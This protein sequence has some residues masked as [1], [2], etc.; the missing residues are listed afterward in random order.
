MSVST[1]DM[2]MMS[3]KTNDTQAIP[4][5]EVSTKQMEPLS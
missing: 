3:K 1:F 2:I 5:I 4:A